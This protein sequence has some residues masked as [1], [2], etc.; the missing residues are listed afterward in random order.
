MAA[1]RRSSITL[2]RSAAMPPKYDGAGVAISTSAMAISEKHQPGDAGR[3]QHVI[4]V[5]DVE[6]ET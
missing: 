3:D 1:G 5:V 2:A 4:H 6:A